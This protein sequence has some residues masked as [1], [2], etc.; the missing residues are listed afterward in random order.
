M[1]TH[2]HFVTR[3]VAPQNRPKAIKH[4]NWDWSGP[5]RRRGSS[6]FALP[7]SNTISI[8]ADWCIPRQTFF[9][10]FQHF[11][12]CSR[13]DFKWFFRRSRRRQKIILKAILKIQ[14]PSSPFQLFWKGGKDLVLSACETVGSQ[15]GIRNYSLII[16]LSFSSVWRLR[17]VLEW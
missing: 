6:N 11:E 8:P 17:E 10:R 5:N 7:D 13:G 3:R 15:A 9:I 2:S 4:S 14:D 16:G 1:Y 12:V